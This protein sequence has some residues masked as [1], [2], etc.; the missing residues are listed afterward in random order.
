[1]SSSEENVDKMRSSCGISVN[2]T[3]NNYNNGDQVQVCSTELSHLNHHHH[4]NVRQQLEGV[5]SSSP[6][7]IQAI[8]TTMSSDPS[9]GTSTAPRQYTET[10]DIFKE[11]PKLS[12]TLNNCSNF[13]RQM[14]TNSLTGN[15]HPAIDHS[16]SI[17]S[18]VKEIVPST[19]NHPPH[20][21]PLPLLPSSSSISSSTYSD[22]T[23][24]CGSSF[25]SD[26]NCHHPDHHLVIHPLSYGLHQQQPQI[27]Y[28][29]PVGIDG[30]GHGCHRYSCQDADVNYMTS[31]G[32][33]LSQVTMNN[34]NLSHCTMRRGGGGCL[35]SSCSTAA[36]GGNFTRSY[37]SSSQLSSSDYGSTATG[38]TCPN[39][40]IYS[41]LS[42]YTES[43]ESKCLDNNYL[44]SKFTENGGRLSPIETILNPNQ[45]QLAPSTH[46]SH[47]SHYSLSRHS[48]YGDT[49][50]PSHEHRNQFSDQNTILDSYATI[51]RMKEPS[52]ILSPRVVLTSEENET[53]NQVGNT[54]SSDTIQQQ[55]LKHKSNIEKQCAKDSEKIKAKMGHKSSSTFGLYSSDGKI[56]KR[57]GKRRKC[58]QNESSSSWI[59]HLLASCPFI[60]FLVQRRGKRRHKVLAS[61]PGEREGRTEMEEGKDSCSLTVLDKSGRKPFGREMTGNE[62]HDDNE[63]V[64]EE[65]FDLSPSNCNFS[66]SA[67]KCLERR[68]RISVG[69][70][71]MKKDIEYLEVKQTEDGSINFPPNNL[72]ANFPSS[73]DDRS[74]D[75]SADDVE[76]TLYTCKSKRSSTSSCRTF[77]RLSIFLLI[78][79]LVLLMLNYLVPTFNIYGLF[80]S[81]HS[82]SASDHYGDVNGGLNPSERWWKEGIFYEIFPPS[83]K[84][85][86]S[87]GFGDLN[88]IREKLSYLKSDLGVTGIRLNS[89]FRALD[90]PFQYDHV[91]D[92]KSVDPH[93]GTLEDFVQLV[94][95]AHEMNLAILL[96]I[97]PVMTSDQHPWAT[98]WLLNKSLSAGDFSSFYAPNPKNVS[99]TFELISWL[100]GSPIM[101]THKVVLECDTIASI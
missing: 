8:T 10:P 15:V 40:S 80:P 62:I 93:I 100:L 44:E 89:I 87:D 70:G 6:A 33:R 31:G 35:S 59:V 58:F 75:R 4:F 76:A 41:P 63:E 81:I 101:V 52:L 43:I 42:V 83:F 12:N 94:N 11:L 72:T 5:S 67:V 99:P 14:D 61:F 48:I 77:H 27:D 9:R 85:S 97:N 73:S 91:V 74:D 18:T 64:E 65:C 98:Q 7:T 17:D 20:P 57:R 21:P 29:I 30:S 60:C 16:T 1:M 13:I 22:N 26:N 23:L 19:T 84:D 45:Y 82:S 34:S 69:D 24:T 36:R 25:S 56:T 38:P 28:G 54:T 51:Q 46:S 53:W 78:S 71:N 90:Y 96:D 79:L 32:Q 50:Y 49:I 37:S 88:G 95:E 39:L 68:K 55:Y 66:P 86:N 3:C 47:G 2:S 92:F